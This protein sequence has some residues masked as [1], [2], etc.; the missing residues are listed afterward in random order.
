MRIK[1]YPTQ[2]LENGHTWTL[3][4]VLNDQGE[5]I[6]SEDFITNYKPTGSRIVTDEQ[7]RILMSDGRYVTPESLMAEQSAR[8]ES[9]GRSGKLEPMPEPVREEFAVD[10][11]AEIDA[12]IDDWLHRVREDG[13]TKA[14]EIA[15]GKLRGSRVDA[16]AVTSLRKSPEAWVSGLRS[17]VVER[18]I[19]VDGRRKS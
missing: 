17:S 3:V 4:E 16:D 18:A 5:V 6:Y 11:D 2:Q 12:L 1:R 13:S 9:V 10:V 14:E 15:A 19:P 8:L 7:G